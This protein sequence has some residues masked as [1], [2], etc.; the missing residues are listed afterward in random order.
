MM[1]KEETENKVRKR[2][3]KMRRTRGTA[4]QDKTRER[5]WKSR[6]RETRKAKDK[7]KESNNEY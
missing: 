3:A 5:R 7:N 4:E 1:K 6:I 2:G